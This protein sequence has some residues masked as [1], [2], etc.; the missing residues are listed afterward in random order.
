MA[1]RSPLLVTPDEA[2]LVLRAVNRAMRPVRGSGGIKVSETDK[3][4]NLAQHTAASCNNKTWHIPGRHRKG[5]TLL[6]G[7]LCYQNS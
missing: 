5:H 4:L 3:S 2:K 6:P 7:W 1:Q